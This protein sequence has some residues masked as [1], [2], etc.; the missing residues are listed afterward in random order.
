MMKSGR[1]VAPILVFG[2]VLIFITGCSSTI[3]PQEIVLTFDGKTCHY[4][5]P[6]VITEGEVTI[7]LNNE[8]EYVA[9]LWAARLDEGRT[10]QEMLDYIGPPGTSVELPSWSD[11]NM[12]AAKVPDNPNATVYT[13]REGLYAI[14]CCTCWE[15][16]GPRGVWPGASLDVKAK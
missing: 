4:D 8:T 3:K 5:G 10:W 6:N 7:I 1:S 12:I 15:F 14:C 2:A 9:S 13:L 11:G 16:Q